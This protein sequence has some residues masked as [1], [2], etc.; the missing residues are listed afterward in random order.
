MKIAKTIAEVRK[1][2]STL[3]G[4]IG[5]IPTMGY[6]HEGHFS[7][8]RKAQE[9]NSH[10][11]VSIF[12]NPKQ[13][14]PHEDLKKYPRDIQKDLTMLESIKTDIVFTPSVN[15]LYPI[16][17]ETNV[18]L[19]N[20]SHKQEG[21]VRPGHF[22]GVGTV[23]TKLFNITQPT[24]VYLGQK[25]A[26]QVVVVKKMVTDLNFPLHVVVC[27][28]VR[29]SDGLAMSSRNVF[30]KSTKRHEASILYKSLNLA[31]EIIKK[32]E[33][34]TKNIKEKME[35]LIQSTSGKIDYISIAHPQTLDEIAEA[36]SGAIISIAV[37]FGSTRL[38]DNV[39]IE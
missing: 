36:K 20:L 6:L 27:D 1:I 33:K 39:I 24:H 14:A 37:R 25:D 5:F 21:K 38:I 17:Y 9:Q 19:D 7:L 22:T 8:V 2:R 30:L 13:F 12:V 34:D 3:Q 35:K 11:I 23:L 10:V 31:Q 28:T 26:Q 29:E 32:G 16:N 15:E 4:T 18:N